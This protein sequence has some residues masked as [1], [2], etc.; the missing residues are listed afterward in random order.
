MT[1][2]ASTVL[3]SLRYRNAYVAIDWLCEAFGFIPYAVHAHGHVVHHAV[4]RFGR[5]MVILGSAEDGG[6]RNLPDALPD[7]IG[8]RETQTCYVVV[9]DIDAHHAR[10]LRAGAELVA[11]LQPREY[12]GRGYACRDIEGHVWWFGNRDPW[13]HETLGTRAA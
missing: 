2:H 8:G 4:L 5:G 9:E 1:G 6:D 3:P 11:P 13:Q 12:G 10:A 7:E